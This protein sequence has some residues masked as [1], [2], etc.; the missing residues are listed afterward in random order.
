MA[1]PGMMELMKQARGLKKIQKKA[2]KKEVSAT[3]GDGLVQ[4]VCNGK[5]EVKRILI[6]QSLLQGGDKRILQDLVAK[7][8][9]EALRKS[10]EAVAGEIQKV[11]GKLGLPTDEAAAEAEME[12]A[13]GDDGEGGRLRRW[14]KR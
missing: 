5:P 3:V 1:E 12:D 11:A 6:D 9:N 10:Q 13:D 14:L 2:E 4:V 8:V 7:G